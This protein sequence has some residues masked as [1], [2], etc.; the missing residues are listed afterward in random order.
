MLPCYLEVVQTMADI[1]QCFSPSYLE[2]CKAAGLFAFGQA[3]AEVG[4]GNVE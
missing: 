4:P 3:W 1:G 2:G